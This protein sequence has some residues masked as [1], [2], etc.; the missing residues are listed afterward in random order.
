M[1]Y[2]TT[3]S[4][5]MV[6]LSV[7]GSG[8][9]Q[10]PSTAQE[11]GAI[12]VERSLPT[13][14][15]SNGRATDDTATATP[16]VTPTPSLLNT[17][18]FDS[19]V[20]QVMTSQGADMQDERQICESRRSLE[21]TFLNFTTDTGDRYCPSYYDEIQCWKASLPGNVTMPCPTFFLGI[22][23]SNATSVVRVC[24]TNGTWGN[25]NKSDYYSCTPVDTFL[26][27]EI[28]LLRLS[29]IGNV[30]YSISLCTTLGA[31]LIL[32]TCKSLWCLQNYIH[33]NFLFSF[34][35]ITVTLLGFLLAENNSDIYSD[36][37]YI[38][39]TI[40]VLLTAS[41]ANFCWMLVE[42]IYLYSIL[43]R[44]VTVTL[45]TLWVYALIGWVVPVTLGVIDVT[46]RMTGLDDYQTKNEACIE[47][48]NIDY[49]IRIPICLIVVINVYFLVHIIVV[50]IRRQRSST[51]SDIPQYKKGARALLVLTPLLGAA[52]LFF[53][54]EPTPD[55]PTVATHIYRYM[56]VLLQSTQGFFVA[57][58]YVFL[59]PE[60][61]KL[62]KRRFASLRENN[63]LFS[64]VS[65]RN[66]SKPSLPNIIFF[67]KTTKDG[68][69]NNARLPTE[70]DNNTHTQ[71]G[72]A[73]YSS[74]RSCNEHDVGEPETTSLG[75]EAQEN[76][77]N[78][79]SFHHD[80]R[81]PDTDIE[82]AP[83]VRHTG[84]DDEKEMVEDGGRG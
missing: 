50:I 82:S 24:L 18:K 58:F 12:S 79:N 46:V 60:V 38:C 75:K 10:G 74:L 9:G 63:T 55:E 20:K 65:S 44:G 77:V 5:L 57:L 52:Y 66:E 81:C 27:P 13:S 36:G 35:I 7:L 68:E 71:N 31:L 29:V 33:M 41:M 40:A 69:G 45:K 70:G 26:E 67:A 23:Y 73:P 49:I 64:T 4:H 39:P 6:V 2:I 8:W 11:A 53:L 48:N 47:N 1:M 30:G 42:G 54:I 17:E 34:I 78:A 32:I 80:Q 56:Q 14:P 16:M 19:L 83:F 62:I 15:E 43:V 28:H 37:P 21:P 51:T 22:Q 59:N 76:D 61:H 25:D 84:H 72:E 3:L